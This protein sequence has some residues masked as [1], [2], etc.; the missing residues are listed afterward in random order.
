LSPVKALRRRTVKWLPARFETATASFPQNLGEAE[1]LLICHRRESFLKPTKSPRNDLHRLRSNRRLR[2]LLIVT[3]SETAPIRAVL[4]Q[5][6]LRFLRVQAIRDLAEV[7]DAN[8]ASGR[9]PAFTEYLDARFLIVIVVSPGL[10]HSRIA[11]SGSKES[12]HKGRASR[13]W[14]LLR[15]SISDHF[16]ARHNRWKARHQ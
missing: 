4:S 8:R 12:A 11:A 2:F 7:H 9:K 5:K 6:S 16:P 15:S 14:V 3:R 13:F 10:A 1:V